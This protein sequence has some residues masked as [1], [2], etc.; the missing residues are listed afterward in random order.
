MRSPFWT[1]AGMT[2]D[3]ISLQQFVPAGIVRKEAA[4]PA[5]PYAGECCWVSI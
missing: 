2:A 4:G 5:C 3:T 1:D